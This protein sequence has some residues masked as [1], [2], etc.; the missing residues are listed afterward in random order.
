[1]KKQS[2]ISLNG[3]TTFEE[4]KKIV[5]ADFKLAN[6]SRQASILGRK[7]V[8]TGKAKFGIFGDG[9]EVAQIAMAKVF[10]K[11]DFRSGYYR[12]QT[13]AFA[14]GISTIKEFFAQLYADT[15]VRLEP[16]SGGR[17]MN[18]HFANRLLDDDG[19]WKNLMEMK[20]TSADI[21]PTASQMIRLVGLAY[22]SKLYRENRLLD[23]M[24][25]FSDKG[26]EVAFGTIG[27]ASCAEGMFFEAMN[28]AAVLRIPMAV[29][30][31]DNGFGISV[32]SKYQI[33][34]ES[35]SNVLIGFEYDDKFKQGFKIHS[36]K[37]WDYP[38][39]VAMYENGIGSVREDHI[40][41][42]F[43]VQEVTQPQGHSTSGSHERYKT[44]ERLEWEK[45]FCCISQMKKWII[46]E[47]IATEEELDEIE[48]NAKDYVKK[49]QLEAWQDYIDPI[50]KENN[51]VRNLFSEIAK[52]GNHSDEINAV[53]DSLKKSLDNNRKVISEAV[54]EVLL[55]TSGENSDAREKLKEWKNKYKKD[56]SKRYGSHLFSESADSAMNVN[57]VKPVYSADSKILDGR[58]VLNAFFDIAFARDPRIFAIG[59]DLGFLGDVNQGM[60]KLQEKYG[61]LRLTD[62]GIREAT[63][64]GQGIG[65]ALRGLKPIVE[66]QY[67]D[68]LL[69]ALQII[70][71]DLACLQ[72]RTAGGQK[73]PLI[74]RTRGHR[75]EG[76]WHSGSPMGTIINSFRGVH[77]CVP[78]DMTRA[79]G[80]YN[81][82]LKSDE[83]A[84]IIERLNAYRLKEHLPDNLSEICVPLGVPEI[85]TA[86][87]DVTLVTYGA[88]VDIAKA[89][90]EKLNKVNISC[91]LIDVQTLL[92]F[93]INKIILESLKKTNRI[94]FLDED[95]PGGAS[96]FMMQNVLD[97]DGGY[98]YLDSDPKCLS[99]KEHRP[100]YGTD[101]DYFSKPNSEDV[102]DAV[103]EIMNESDPKQYPLF[104]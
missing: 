7:E 54:H 35:I 24:K 84:L 45:E 15:D 79:A 43:D 26:N 76:I 8:L 16:A 44:K 101:G 6:E 77:V 11:G 18:G 53:S 71:D 20:N 88:C 94:L 39:L 63:I 42:V 27:N 23:G 62:T 2:K 97:R 78:R 52:S 64:V 65:C 36:A 85:L 74:I 33:A 25:S 87:T 30:I 50:K 93:D 104:F 80:F 17:S 102:F 95:V 57:E 73:A 61:E 86:G 41:A 69:Y 37:G 51:E 92:P 99:A 19:N 1:M 29:S 98:R 22:A 100:A 58:E 89:A 9:K 4:Y 21:S 81:T 13:F 46:A 91:E 28:A 59:E 66:I 10:R 75:L 14:T 82:I 60:A 56:N 3:K 38:G 90:I 32:P 49:M 83:P 72:Y 67:L 96:A 48:K 31:W 70:S 40:P 12:D 34:K 55:I 103:Y 68:Y 47:A 5:L